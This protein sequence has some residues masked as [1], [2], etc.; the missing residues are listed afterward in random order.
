MRVTVLGQLVALQ[1]GQYKQI[2]IKN[3]DEQESSWTRYTM[4]TIC[5]NWQGKIPELGD[6]GYFEF[7]EVQGG[8]QFFKASTREFDMYKYNGCYFLN[9]VEQKEQ[10]INKD[11]K[12]E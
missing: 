3:L 12:F 9:F 2:V 8:Q 11:F 7:E 6:I 4:M 1:E 5:P 10:I